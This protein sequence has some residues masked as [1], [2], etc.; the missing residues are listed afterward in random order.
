MIS[1]VN[2]II[3]SFLS[4]ED[5]LNWDSLV[6]F[7]KHENLVGL[8]MPKDSIIIAILSIFELEV[9][10]SYRLEIF[11]EGL[12]RCFSVLTKLDL[13]AETFFVYSINYFC[14]LLTEN[15]AMCPGL[16]FIMKTSS[17]T[18]VRY[19]LSL[20]YYLSSTLI[21]SSILHCTHSPIFVVELLSPL[22]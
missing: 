10:E 8:K 20:L 1:S 22:R 16:L 17:H 15:I 21:F 18:L 7:I 14:N 9:L 11:H 2:V 4:A 12:N 3:D 19:I 5:F 6:F 13:F